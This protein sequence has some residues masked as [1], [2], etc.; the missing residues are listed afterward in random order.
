M[1]IVWIGA[2]RSRGRR[3]RDAALDNVDRATPGT[4]TSASRSR[5]RSRART[6]ERPGGAQSGR[7]ADFFRCKTGVRTRRALHRLHPLAPTPVPA[8][9]CGITV[10]MSGEKWERIGNAMPKAI[11]DIG[12][13]VCC[14]A[15][16][17]A[18]WVFDGRRTVWR[19]LAEGKPR[20]SI[21]RRRGLA[22]QARGCRKQGWFS[23]KRQAMCADA[24]DPVGVYFGTTSG[25][26]G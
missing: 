24:H 5:A 19:R 14:I 16:S 23:V 10:W 15:R 7:R 22:P 3:R 4:S 12:F 20:P 8:E 6:A 9:H 17:D 11:G 13:P 18:L 2:S 1:R 26:S 21:A 25:R